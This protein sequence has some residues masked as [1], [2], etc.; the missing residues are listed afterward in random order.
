MNRRMGLFSFLFVLVFI[1]TTFSKPARLSAERQQPSNSAP[2]ACK[3]TIPNGSQPP[4]KDWGG[5]GSFAW[6]KA[7]AASSYGNGELWTLLPRGGTLFAGHDQQGRLWDK[8][9]W[10]RTVHGHLSVSGRR[11]GGPET[12]QTGPSEE[13]MLGRDTGLLVEGLAFPS[14][15]CWEVTGKAGGTELTFVI[16][17]QASGPVV[18]LI[19]AWY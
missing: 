12:F 1:L 19:P 11:L 4:D 2:F 15:G 17:V 5:T 18:Q 9:L 7:A 16:N 10:Y 3:V 13:T 8:W 14:E 6:E